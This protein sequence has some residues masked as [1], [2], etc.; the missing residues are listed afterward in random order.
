[1]TKQV[2]GLS[3]EMVKM[4]PIEVLTDKDGEQLVALLNDAA[5]VARQTTGFNDLYLHYRDGE[6][7]RVRL[8]ANPAG[9]TQWVSADG[10]WAG[11]LDAL[12][13]ELEPMRAQLAQNERRASLRGAAHRT[14]TRRRRT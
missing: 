9:A 1:M 2:G 3:D 4:K 7:W 10:P 14:A 5:R 13:A 8:M 12:R 11:F 6:G